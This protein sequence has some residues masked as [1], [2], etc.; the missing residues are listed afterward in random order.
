MDYV[1]PGAF[2]TCVLPHCESSCVNDDAA[3]F[4]I[5]ISSQGDGFLLIALDD[6]RP[7]AAKMARRPGTLSSKMAPSLLTAS[8]RAVQRALRI[9]SKTSR[10]RPGP[11]GPHLI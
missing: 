3:S 5:G 6:E 10:V 11:K 7:H 9:Q 2:D 8:A 4:V 1:V